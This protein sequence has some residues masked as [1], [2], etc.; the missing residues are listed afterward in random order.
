MERTR[1]ICVSSQTCASAQTPASAVKVF[2]LPS[3]HHKGLDYAATLCAG[4]IDLS[5]ADLGH[6]RHVSP[7]IREHILLCLSLFREAVLL[8]LLGIEGQILLLSHFLYLH[9]NLRH[10]QGRKGNSPVKLRYQDNKISGMCLLIQER[11]TILNFMVLEMPF[12]SLAYLKFVLATNSLV[13]H[14]WAVAALLWF[15]VAE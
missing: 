9:S 4:V 13:A 11:K 8:G 15:S 2:T 1:E 10:F 5:N 14:L 6:W 7:L 12:I 3:A